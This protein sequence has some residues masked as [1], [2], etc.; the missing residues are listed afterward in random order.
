MCTQAAHQALEKNRHFRVFQKFQALGVPFGCTYWVSPFGQREL[1]Y[2]SLTRF[3]IMY[4]T[5]IAKSYSVAKITEFRKNE[6]FGVS[7][8]PKKKLFWFRSV[9]STYLSSYVE[10]GNESQASFKSH[11]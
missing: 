10:V 4:C 5:T 6:D 7:F 1:L 11:N 2:M 8:R 9:L 3:S